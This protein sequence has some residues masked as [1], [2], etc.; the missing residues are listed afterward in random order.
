M[1]INES[2][3]RA[4]FGDTRSPDREFR[5]KKN[6]EKCDFWLENLLFRPQFKNH[7]TYTTEICTQCG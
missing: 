1:E 6:I 5:H 2:V 3:I 4:N 7:K